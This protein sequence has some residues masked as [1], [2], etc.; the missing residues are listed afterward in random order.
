MEPGPST[1]HLVSYLT[2]LEDN[3]EQVI[4]KKREM[5]ELDRMR[6]N[7]RVAIRHLMKTKDEKSWIAMG[8]TLFR[9]KTVDAKKFLEEGK[10]IHNR[11]YVQ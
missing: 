1:E 2:D 6:N 11:T 3:A 5:I 8:N 9:F 10:E 7:N 4:T